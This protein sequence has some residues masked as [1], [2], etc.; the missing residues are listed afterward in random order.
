M[1][2]YWIVLLVISYFIV[3]TVLTA[4]LTWLKIEISED[5]YILFTVFA[6]PFMIPL[7]LTGE[8]CMF[9]YDKI[10]KEVI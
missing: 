9:L 2:W 5:A 6:W 1:A 7:I 8:L 10:R 4:L 3:G